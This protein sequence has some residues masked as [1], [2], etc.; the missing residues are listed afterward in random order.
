[1]DQA[2]GQFPGGD[3]QGPAF[4]EVHVSGPLQQ[5]GGHAGGDA[6]DTA[7]AGRQDH[8]ALGAET[9]A[10][11]RCRLV[12][13]AVATQLAALAAGAFAPKGLLGPGFV[14]HPDA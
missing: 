1:M 9:A 11:N 7:H 14:G 4:L 12:V 10:R 8:H 6:A 13:P 3:H 2:P 5:V